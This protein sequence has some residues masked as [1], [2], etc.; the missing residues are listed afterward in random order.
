MTTVLRKVSEILDTFD[1]PFSVIEAQDDGTIIEVP[2][3]KVVKSTVIE[4]QL[5]EEGEVV[6]VEVEVSSIVEIDTAQIGVPATWGDV[7]NPLYFDFKIGDTV[8][9]WAP[10]P[11][12]RKVGITQTGE[13]GIVT[14]KQIRINGCRSNIRKVISPKFTPLK[15]EGCKFTINGVCRPEQQFIDATD[16]SIKTMDDILLIRRDVEKHLT[17]DEVIENGDT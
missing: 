12:T 17:F 14:Y 13:I 3:T 4:E 7:N 1:F 6:E 8:Y 5:N 10:K 9:S 11:G 2:T 15:L 16:G